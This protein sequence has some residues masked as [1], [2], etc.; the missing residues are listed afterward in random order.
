VPEKEIF[1][2]IDY[3]ETIGNAVPY[4]AILM[5]LLEG[6]AVHLEPIV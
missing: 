2:L 5:G 6:V 4:A 3:T 1:V